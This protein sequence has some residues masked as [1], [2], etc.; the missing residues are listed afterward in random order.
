MSSTVRT[1]ALLFLGRAVV[2]TQALLG[3]PAARLFGTTPTRDPYPTYES[4]RSSGAL[5]KSRMGLYLT[6]SHELCDAVL[7]DPAYGV[8]P[9]G[10][11]SPIDSSGY[12]D[13]RRLV[14]PVEESFLVRNPPDHTRL[15]RLV[16]PWFTPRGLRAQAATVERVV[17]EYLDEVGDRPTF[18]LVGDFAARV[19]VRVIAELLGVPGADQA[20]FARW[21]KA[22]VNALDGVRD[23]RELRALHEGLRE[24][25]AFLDD[26][27]A[28]RR[29][30]PGDDI[31]SA[32]VAHDDLTRE[33]L[34][35]TTELLLVAGF[36]TTVNLIGNAALA[37]LA[38]PEV[39]ARL[40]DDPACAEAVV[41]ETLRLDPPVQYTVRM[42]FEATHLAG[43]RVPRRTPVVL[44]LAGAN[45]DPA[46]FTDPHRFD[47]DRPDV[48]AHLAF[49]SGI[50]YCLGAGLARME[51]AAALRGLFGRYPNLRAAG[52]I[53]RRPSRLIRGA[54]HFPVTTGAPQR[55]PMAPATT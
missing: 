42:P 37:V 49:S 12:V 31:V 21:G 7:R 8:V 24:F 16:A 32:L 3:D 15:R 22:L 30:R 40:L 48:R 55:R 27:V 44:L 11:L 45:R 6:A 36:E 10:D 51:A 34:V 35:A 19:P 13:G 47:P 41:E 17:A 50:H 2:R 4:V 25:E 1:A 46:V 28:H 38:H 23:L 29:A 9:A 52:R 53:R 5:V 39:R 54:A 33:D 26:L 18:D 43:A 14:N 20:A